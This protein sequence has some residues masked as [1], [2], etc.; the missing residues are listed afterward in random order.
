MNVDFVELLMIQMDQ[1]NEMY[2]QNVM[3]YQ[4]STKRRRVNYVRRMKRRMIEKRNLMKREIQ[5]KNKI[6]MMERF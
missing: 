2:R 3:M 6:D 1:I 4:K 5:P